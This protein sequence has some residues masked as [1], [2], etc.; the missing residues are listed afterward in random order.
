[1]KLKDETLLRQLCYVDGAWKKADSGASIDVTDPATDEVLGSVPKFLGAETREAIAAAKRAF[2]AWAAKT[3]GERATILRRWNDLMLA[4]ADDLALIMTLEQGKPL[5]ESKGEVAYSASFIEWFAEEGKRIYGDV[6]PSHAA[7]KRIVVLKQPVG[8]VCAITPWNFPSAMIG[9]KA[10]PA[11]AAGCTFVC[12]PATQTPFSALALGELAHRA[13]IP[14]GVFNVITGSAREIGAEMTSSPDVAKLT[15]TG[16]TEIGRQLLAQCAPT[17]KKVSMELGGNAPFIV[18]DDADLDA[19]V[20]GA[21]ASKYRNTGQTCVCANRLYVQAGV[22]DAFVEKLAAAVAKLKVGPGIEP[23]VTQG[24]LID[25]AAVEKMKEHIADA[26]AKGGRLVAGGKP[27]KLGHTFFEPTLIADATQDMLVA[28]EETFGPL[29]PVIRFDTDADAIRMA[30]D[31]EF[32]LAAYFYARDLG[33]VW[34]VAEAMESGIVGINTGI[35]S[36]AV[37]PFGGVKQSGLGREGSKYGID[38]Y[39]EIKYLCL[40]GL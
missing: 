12:K 30:N 25:Q 11:L 14:P 9:R 18:F 22:Y 17:I 23:G 3:A 5:A 40:G 37:A 27:H 34:R 20:E 31:T 21:I 1:M 39:L 28:K 10:G 15:F 2:P 38:D 13:G 4:N 35:I 24:P 19:A 32:G 36:T 16:S 7:D 6:I 8:V 29:A 26:L 33:R